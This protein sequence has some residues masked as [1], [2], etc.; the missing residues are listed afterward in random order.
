MNSIVTILYPSLLSAF[1]KISHHLLVVIII[2]ELGHR[3]STT[4]I[5]YGHK[6]D[7]GLHASQLMQMH[8]QCRLS[9]LLPSMGCIVRNYIQYT[10]QF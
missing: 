10:K 3:I 7:M 9:T 8:H 5:S 1:K 2:N 6:A 4:C